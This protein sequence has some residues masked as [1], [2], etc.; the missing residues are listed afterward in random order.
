MSQPGACFLS[1]YTEVKS[2]T[3]PLSFNVEL[4]NIYK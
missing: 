4:F 3:N 2:I 1:V